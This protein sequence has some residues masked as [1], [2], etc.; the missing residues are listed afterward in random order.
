MNARTLTAT[1]LAAS[2]TCTPTR[3]G[4][5]SELPAP[6]ILA[7]LPLSLASVSA[8]GPGLGPDLV[9][10][11]NATFN[12]ATG[13]VT[14]G[15]AS[16]SATS[17]TSASAS[18]AVI[19]W[20]GLT[21]GLVREV[22]SFAISP[23]PGNSQSQLLFQTA[24]PLSER[25]PAFHPE[26]GVPRPAHA[27]GRV[28]LA[29][30]NEATGTRTL[31]LSLVTTTGA[32]PAWTRAADY[33]VP[34]LVEPSGIDWDHSRQTLWV[35][36]DGGTLCRVSPL[37]GEVEESRVLG[38]DLEAVRWIPALDLLLVTR[39]TDDTLLV[40]SPETLQ[41]ISTVSLVLATNVS[42][43]FTVGGDGFEGLAVTAVEGRTV[44]FLL[45]NQ[46]D[47]HCLYEATLTIP[48]APPAQLT[49]TITSA[50]PQPAVNLSEVMIDWGSRRRFV[51]HGYQLPPTLV[52]L[53]SPAIPLVEVSSEGC[54]IAP[55]GTLWIANDQGGLTR[56]TSE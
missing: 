26:V 35:V 37:T 42:P 17:T 14:L 3:H 55:D 53:G 11:R 43:A 27:D 7:A 51:L 49:A 20:S 31:T 46:N 15:P 8:T 48:L 22:S 45:A 56:Y 5:A 24:S 18:L 12:Q 54:T 39:E 47:P 2:C 34:S 16:A 40:V 30:R 33:P 41:T 23:D 28:L 13:T 19:R 52:P 32:I 1:L 4:P 21:D 10:A 38:G 9:F 25:W 50:S 29:I 44:N 36:E 6:A